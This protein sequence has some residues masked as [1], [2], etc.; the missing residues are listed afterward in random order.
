MQSEELDER[1]KVL[2]EE[3][4]TDEAA[5]VE[6]FEEALDEVEERTLVDLSDEKKQDYAISLVRSDLVES[7]AYGGG[8]EVDVLAI[9]HDSIT[10]WVDKDDPRYDESKSRDENPKKDVLLA[11]GVI[12]TEDGLGQAVFIIDETDEVDLGKAAEAFSPLTAFRGVFSISE[13]EN[14]QRGYVVNSTSDTDFEVEEA[15]NIPDSKQERLEVLHK[16]V[17]E[18][19]LTNVLEGLS[20]TS[21]WDGG[22]SPADFG[23]DI[24]RIEGNVVDYYVSDDEGKSS[25][26]TILDSSVA[27]GSELEGSPVDGENQRTTGLTC[28]TPTEYMEYGNG[29]RCEFYGTIVQD[30]DGR[31]VMNTRG[32]VP[33]MPRPMQDGSSDEN[34]ERESI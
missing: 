29:S 12:E 20:L 16:F 13:S 23:I 1:L 28:W 3:Y 6:M 21:T 24:K 10:Q 32:I 31:V 5:V 7:T 17:D 27:S 9:G 26:Y 11:N 15:E 22:E 2:S 18:V 34:V 19:T 25:V 33:L 30:N 8:E 4:K 14:L